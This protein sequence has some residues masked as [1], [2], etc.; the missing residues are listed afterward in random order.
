MEMDYPF[1]T[2]VQSRGRRGEGEVELRAPGAPGRL[3]EAKRIHR[4]VEQ[5]PV[6]KRRSYCMQELSQAALSL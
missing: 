1:Q 2:E 5:G 6:P 3:R 4:G